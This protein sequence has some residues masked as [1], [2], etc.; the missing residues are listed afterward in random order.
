V[1]ASAGFLLG[2]L[3]NPENRGNMSLQNVGLSL[4][5]T[6]SKP[7]RLYTS[8]FINILLLPLIIPP[9]QHKVLNRHFCNTDDMMAQF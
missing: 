9:S 8:D 5:Y 2:L 4:N 7:R 1:L 3:F 6:A